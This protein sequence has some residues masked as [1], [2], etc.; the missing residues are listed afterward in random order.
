[1]QLNLN[2]ALVKDLLANFENRPIIVFQ[3]NL[4]AMFLPKN[5]FTSMS[6]PP[7]SEAQPLL[8]PLQDSTNEFESPKMSCSLE[9]KKLATLAYPVLI[10]SVLSY[11]ITIAP[12]FALGHLGTEYLGAIALTTMFCNVT[13]FSIGV[14]LTTA[15]DTLISQAFTGS[16]D[17]FACGKHLQ[18][19]LVLQFLLSI[20]VSLIW[21]FTEP[22]LLFFKQDGE[23]A[24][25]SG[26]FAIFM[27]PGLFP[28]LATRSIMSFLQ[29]QGLMKPGMF[30]NF[31]A[32]A[33]NMILQYTLVW[34][35]LSIGPTGSPIA[36]SLTNWIT[37]FLVIL[38]AV[39]IKGLENLRWGGFSLNEAFNS[40]ELWKFV[41]LGVPG[42]VMLCSEWWAFEVVALAAGAISNSVL[43]AQTILLNVG[44]FLYFIPLGLSV[45]A[46]TRIGN[47]LGA[48]HA[49]IAKNIS[50]S[51]FL[52][53]LI[54]A[55]FNSLLVFSTRHQLGYLFSNDENVVRIVGDVFP[56]VALFQFNDGLACV[57]S[58]VLRGCGRQKFGAAVSIV[59]YYVFALPL[60]MLFAFYFNL[61]LLGLW[62]GLTVGIVFVSGVD[63]IYALRFID[64][65]EEV[66]RAN[67]LVNHADSE[68]LLPNEREE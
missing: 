66:K 15:L 10:S 41:K 7:D 1:V 56:L 22:I 61:E 60:A 32:A 9:A 48:R 8:L 31:L 58:G 18:R 33:T 42:I 28:Y 38:Y 27:I 59:G 53:V 13:G 36:T 64:W 67:D 44:A 40:A 50:K 30:V 12:I 25:I 20:P 21:F 63:T 26:Q 35:S 14:G 37:L 16:N 55:T 47:C 68:Y 39:Y 17:A 34:S 5:S 11:S 51:A 62:I 43:A 19:G 57:G 4:F 2:R 46:T 3:E 6:V 49:K 23:I 65:G 52:L 54:I 29:G 45:A 24:R